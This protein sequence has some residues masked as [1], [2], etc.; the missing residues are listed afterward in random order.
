MNY[1]FLFQKDN[2]RN[3][4]SYILLN[5]KNYMPLSTTNVKQFLFSYARL[6]Y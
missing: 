3:D 1:N 4:I 5:L 2:D 6:K